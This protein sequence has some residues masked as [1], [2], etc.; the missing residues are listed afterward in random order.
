[1]STQHLNKFLI[2]Q[3]QQ[4]DRKA[5]QELYFLLFEKF[6][7]ICSPYVKDNA[8]AKSIVNDAFIKI[9]DK[10]SSMNDLQ[11][12]EAWSNRIVRNTAI[13]H[14]RKN[15][16]YTSRI[17]LEDYDENQA[18]ISSNILQD[19]NG[20]DLLKMIQSLPPNEQLVFSLFFIEDFSHKEISKQLEI[21]TEMSRWILYK[22]RKN[23][24]K[25]YY[26]MNS[27]SI[28]VQ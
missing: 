12:F 27:V 3:C 4:K 9:L 5:I 21:S 16:N 24:K 1:M 15:S 6:M 11:A 14:L 20:Q 7:R 8:E 13:D 19:L 22:A 25:I 18:Q 10:L 28:Q 26:S 23:F 17:R 2:Q